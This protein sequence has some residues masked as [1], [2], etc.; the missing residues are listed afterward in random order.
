M[1]ARERARERERERTREA[2]KKRKAKKKKRTVT[3]FPR[4]FSGELS[5]FHKRARNT[6]VG[7]NPVLECT[8]LPC[9]LRRY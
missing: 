8:F 2:G 6:P 7:R 1:R 9:P 3:L 5:S 4:E